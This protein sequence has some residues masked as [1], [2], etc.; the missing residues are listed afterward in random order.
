M[1]VTLVAAQ[2]L[3]FHTYN[4]YNSNA[5]L[6]VTG[7]SRQYEESANCAWGIS[8]LLKKGFL[9]NYHIYYQMCF[10]NDVQEEPFYIYFEKYVSGVSEN[11]RCLTRQRKNYFCPLDLH[12]NFI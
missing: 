2:Q 3:H 7:I 11:R 6:N 4:T 8:D 12:A 9:Y 5:C 1:Q 10:Q